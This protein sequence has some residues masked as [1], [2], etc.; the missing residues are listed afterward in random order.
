MVQCVQHTIR[1]LKQCCTGNLCR[2]R[3]NRHRAI[4]PVACYELPHIER[5]QPFNLNKMEKNSG[6]SI[7]HFLSA[8][9]QR[10]S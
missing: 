4:A 2:W 5:I 3:P 7:S 8:I 9:Q 1:I 6:T 10:V